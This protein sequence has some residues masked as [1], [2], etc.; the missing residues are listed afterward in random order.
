MDGRTEVRPTWGFVR[1]KILSFFLVRRNSIGFVA[2]R[3]LQVVGWLRV[4]AQ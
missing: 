4:H 1:T 3:V 2:P